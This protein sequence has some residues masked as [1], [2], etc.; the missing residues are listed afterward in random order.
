MTCEHLR[1]LDEA[2]LAAGFVPTFRGQ[3][4]SKNC[5]EWVYFDCA[6]LLDEIERAFDLDACVERHEHRGT[7]DG[8]ERG[9]VC[10][11]HD[12]A[13]MGTLDRD[14]ARTFPVGTDP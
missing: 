2:L 4:W 10:T 7:H 14:G 13:V 6:L 5:R 1:A 9:L 12:D 3:A 8:S 11:I